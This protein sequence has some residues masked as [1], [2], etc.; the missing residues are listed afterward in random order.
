MLPAIPLFFAGEI[1]RKSGGNGGIS[2]GKM[3]KRDEMI[4]NRIQNEDLQTHNCI[5]GNDLHRRQRFASPVTICIAGNDWRRRRLSPSDS[6]IPA[7]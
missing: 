4:S 3:K 2:E 7:I 6:N 1:P 5:A